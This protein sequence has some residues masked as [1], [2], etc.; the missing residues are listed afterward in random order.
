M[1]AGNVSSSNTNTANVNQ[2]HL[3]PK[4]ELKKLSANLQATI[5]RTKLSGNIKNMSELKDAERLIDQKVK[6]DTAMTQPDSTS[7]LLKE[8][9]KESRYIT[10][11]MNVGQGFGGRSTE[12]QRKE[13][14]Y[15]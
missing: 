10:L 15:N 1:D 2:I 3:T 7:R 8:I 5:R 11:A 6:R 12:S 13:L 9:K 14:E 4:K